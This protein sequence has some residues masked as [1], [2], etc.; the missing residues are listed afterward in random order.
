[1]LQKRSADS[2]DFQEREFDNPAL[3][4]YDYYIYDNRGMNGIAVVSGKE[5]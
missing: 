5:I 2:T 4:V 1:M 3:K